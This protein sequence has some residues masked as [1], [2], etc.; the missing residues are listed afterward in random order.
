MK[1]MAYKRGRKVTVNFPRE[2]LMGPI[3]SAAR[4]HRTTHRKNEA[5]FS[6]ISDNFFCIVSSPLS[7]QVY[8]FLSFS[9]IS[10]RLA[11]VLR[12][13]ITVSTSPK[14]VTAKR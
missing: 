3:S 13:Q 7:M 12:S 10:A 14:I 9:S 6:G 2:T 8:L 5:Y 4:Q 11:L 1:S